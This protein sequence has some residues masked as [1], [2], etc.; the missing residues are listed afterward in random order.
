MKRVLL[1]LLT[2]GLL[3]TTTAQNDSIELRTAVMKLDQ[4]LLQ[5]DSVAL[6]KLLDKHLSFAH[7]N[8]WTQSKPDV[9]ADFR[10]GKLHY[11]S[12]E[13]DSIQFRMLTKDLATIMLRVNASGR[14]GEK[15]FSLKLAVMQVWKKD[16][17]GWQL[18]AR[19]SAKVE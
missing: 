4:A 8:G 2:I 12:L 19:Q 11:A 10:S 6:D 17:K 16:K 15:E 7:S 1:L 5:K 13:T 14:V 18:F 9:L 3:E